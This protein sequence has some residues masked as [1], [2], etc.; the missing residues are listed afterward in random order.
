MRSLAKM[1]FPV[2]FLWPV[3][4]NAKL[5]GEESVAQQARDHPVREGVFFEAQ[6]QFSRTPMLSEA[7][8]QYEICLLRYHAHAK[9][10]T[11]VSAIPCSRARVHAGLSNS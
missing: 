8:E 7:Y 4:Q 10:E 6:L 9:R 3:V 1:W 2:G 5:W 11:A